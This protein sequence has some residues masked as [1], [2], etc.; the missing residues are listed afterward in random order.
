M[1]FRKNCRRFGLVKTN[2]TVYQRIISYWWFDPQLSR[3]WLSRYT[4]WATRPTSSQKCNG[5]IIIQTLTRWKKIKII[6]LDVHHDCYLSAKSIYYGN[7]S[8]WSHISPYVSWDCLCR[9]GWRSTCRTPRNTESFKFG[10][11][12]FAYYVLNYFVSLMGF[13]LELKSPL[14]IKTNIFKIPVSCVWIPRTRWR[15]VME[16]GVNVLPI[17]F[18]P[19]VWHEFYF[20]SITI[21]TSFKLDSSN[22]GVFLW[23]YIYIYIYI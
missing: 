10:P 21:F 4:D 9:R 11:Y 19:F 17:F 12:V 5:K 7:W 16:L 1:H 6:D 13:Y 2:T 8:P 20:F 22:S 14:F 18:I 15:T 3:P 23:T